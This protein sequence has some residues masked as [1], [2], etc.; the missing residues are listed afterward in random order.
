MAKFACGINA[1]GISHIQSELDRLGLDWDAQAVASE[2][3]EKPGFMEI[4]T[5]EDS[6]EYEI[7][8]IQAGKTGYGVHG[9]ITISSEHVI[10]DGED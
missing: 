2:I 3:E 7:S 5:T 10:F 4:G 9:W 1:D 8:N 6:Y